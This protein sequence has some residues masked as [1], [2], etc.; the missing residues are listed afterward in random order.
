MTVVASYSAEAKF[1]AMA[2]GICELLMVELNI[3]GD[4]PM[5]LYCDNKATINR[6]HNPAHHDR[7]KHG[8]IDQH[9]FKE[10]IEEKL[11]CVVYLPTVHQIVDVLT[12][13]I[14]RQS[15]DNLMSKLGMVDIFA[16][17]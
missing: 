7:T 13:G 1:Q 15:L 8:E 9:I 5:K 14:P 11:V 17:A 4:E 10:K 6:A 2:Q 12:K 3:Q 16:P